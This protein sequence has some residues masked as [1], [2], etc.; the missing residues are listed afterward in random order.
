MQVVGGQSQ[1]LVRKTS[2]E[3]PEVSVARRGVCPTGIMQEEIV[4]VINPAGV[5][6]VSRPL[7]Q[8]LGVILGRGQ[9]RWRGRR[10]GGVMTA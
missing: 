6:A 9:R 5:T 4:V 3:V 7:G 2:R 10:W 1:L 8:R